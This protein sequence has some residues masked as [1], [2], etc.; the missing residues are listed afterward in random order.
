MDYVVY[1][2]TDHLFLLDKYTVLL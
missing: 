2:M 1:W